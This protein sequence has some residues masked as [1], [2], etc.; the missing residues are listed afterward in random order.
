MKITTELLKNIIKE[1]FAKMQEYGDTFAPHSSP[2][3]MGEPPDDT[4][5]INAKPDGGWSLTGRFKGRRVQVDS[6]DSGESLLT[7]EPNQLRFALAR[8]LLGYFFKQEGDDGLRVNEP[9]LRNVKII[10]NGE[11]V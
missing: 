10:R 8:T 1:E 2:Q 3:G 9:M 5:E 4:L 11:P 6:K 7:K